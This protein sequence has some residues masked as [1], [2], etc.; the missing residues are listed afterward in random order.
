MRYCEAVVIIMDALWG[1]RAVMKCKFWYCGEEEFGD[2]R[3]YVVVRDVFI[4]L[5]FDVQC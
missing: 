1:V 5:N 2:D 3:G 4:S